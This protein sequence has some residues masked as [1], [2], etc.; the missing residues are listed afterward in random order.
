MRSLK[1]FLYLIFSFSMG[2]GVIFFGGPSIFK[3]LVVEYSDGRIEPVN[4]KVTP[5][6]GIQVAILNFELPGHGV[7]RPLNG[8]SRSLNINWSFFD[9]NSFVTLRLGP[10]VFQ[11][12]FQIDSVRLSTPSLLSLWDNGFESLPFKVKAENVTVKTI[13]QLETISLKAFFSFDDFRINDLVITGSKAKAEDRLI[14]EANFIRGKISPIQ[15]TKSITEQPVDWEISIEKIMSHKFG[16][17]VP[18]VIADLKSSS[19]VIGFTL[20]AKQINLQNVS[21]KFED[22]A[23]DGS[24]EIAGLNSELKFL[25]G[26]QIELLSGS[27][28]GNK[29]NFGQFLARISSSDNNIFSTSLKANL[30]DSE[31]YLQE[32]YIGQFPKGYVKA[33][34]KVDR[35]AAKLTSRSKLSLVNP[36]TGNVEMAIDLL[37][38]LGNAAAPFDCWDTKCEFSNFSSK[39]QIELGKERIDAHSYCDVN[40]CS[41]GQLSH[42]VRTSDTSEI[43]KILGGMKIFNPLVLAYLYSVFSA[44]ETFGKGHEINL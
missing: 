17:E 6:L 31:I 3:W 19:G 36:N 22:I 8:F 29:I 4:V 39:Y 5:S 18:E 15:L 13:G 28:L 44:G 43:F 23:V 1:V 21:G 37:A 16:T 30:H 11:D 25:D 10:T 27:L 7:N 14:F 42:V 2:W 24:F 34:V 26:T 33:L 32:E 41:L 12:S 9:P 40:A 38:K 20:G 35:R